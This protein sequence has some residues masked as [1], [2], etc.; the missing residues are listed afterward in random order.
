M[1]NCKFM[2][3]LYSATNIFSKISTFFASYLKVT[4]FARQNNA[5]EQKKTCT[6]DELLLT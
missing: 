1:H 6:F 5:F 4:I 3:I 2:Q